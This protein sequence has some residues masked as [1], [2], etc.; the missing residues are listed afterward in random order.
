MTSSS[1]NISQ[2]C[3]KETS[4]VSFP[5]STNMTIGS[6]TAP[7]Q[8]VS[9][10]DISS[11]DVSLDDFQQVENKNKKKKIKRKIT[12]SDIKRKRSQFKINVISTPV[13]P[14]HDLSVPISIAAKPLLQNVIQQVQNVQLVQGSQQ[15]HDVPLAPHLQHMA[16]TSESTRYAQTRYPLPP[17]IIRF[18]AGK[19]TSNQ[20]KEGLTTFCNQKYQ[21]EINI[22]NCR[23]SNRSSNNEYDFL[24]FLK[25]A[26]SFSF[27]LEQ[28]HWP[29]TFC[30]ENYTFPYS[31]SI[32]PQLSL[33]VKNVDLNLD[34]NE[35]CQD[36]KTSYPQVKNVIRLKNKFNNDIKL[37]KLEF[38]S[39]SVRDE[40]L[41]KRK[42]TVDY[43]VYDIDEYLAPANILI[44]SKCMG[45]GHFMK[46]CKQVKSTCRTC[47]ECSDDLKL[48]ICSNIEK[49][50]H[51]G[52]NHKSNSLKCQVVKLFRSE[53]TR[54]LLSSNN[55]S[56]STNSKTVNNINNTNFRYINSNFP[57]MPASQLLQF[58]TNN[59]MLTKLDDLLEKITEVNNRF[60]SLELKYNNIEQ[61]MIEK[62]ESDSL[63]KENLNFL[64]KQSGE[65]KK[66]V[67]HHGISIDRHEKLFMKLIVPM[68]DD[69]FFLI[70][71]QNQDK[72]GNPIDADL[73]LKLE[74]YLIQMK[75]AKEGKSF[76]N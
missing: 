59:P 12:T 72:K 76:T 57:P 64:S 35:F 21:M 1:N 32:P 22:L 5:G 53:L 33:L 60:S 9:S 39:S 46:Q 31:P 63:V 3:S 75:K 36:I 20:I 45:L 66:E 8:D 65:L 55:H 38:T 25:D 43:I 42:I 67:V 18:N 27:L 17:F 69:L 15:D 24:L 50:I 6:P 51:C 52:L 28:I 29:I 56:T 54:K 37:V 70:A 13:I 14:A 71:S 11:N 61:F 4:E 23:L 10:N 48:H 2:N 40:L 62:K 7:I 68:F 30:N 34:F 47:G 49:C 74:R 19:V 73:K 44:C 58:S 41:I 26:Y 16:I